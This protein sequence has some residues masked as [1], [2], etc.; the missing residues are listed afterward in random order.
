MNKDTNA[1][2]SEMVFPVSSWGNAGTRLIVAGTANPLFVKIH[3]CVDKSKRD[4]AFT[5]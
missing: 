4:L 2:G 3:H 1:S 5:K